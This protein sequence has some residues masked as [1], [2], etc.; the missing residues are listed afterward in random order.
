MRVSTGVGWPKDIARIAEDVTSGNTNRIKD[1]IM[2]KQTQATYQG[3]LEET[4]S[5]HSHIY[6]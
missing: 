4:P 2:Q 6:G 3:S 5:Y 1:I